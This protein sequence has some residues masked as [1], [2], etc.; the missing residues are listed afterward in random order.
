VLGAKALF[1]PN[2]DCT[3]LKG[4]NAFALADS[5][6][7]ANKNKAPACVMAFGSSNLEELLP[8]L[9]FR[10]DIFSLISCPKTSNEANLSGSCKNAH[11]THT[12]RIRTNVIFRKTLT[13]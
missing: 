9:L 3:A 13:K 10:L 8:K 2:K 6:A 11:D 7:K 5:C 1:S 12:E 4:S